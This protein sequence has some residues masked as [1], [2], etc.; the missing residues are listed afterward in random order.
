M[1]KTEVTHPIPCYKYP[2]TALL[3]DDDISFL[4]N[5]SAQLIPSLRFEK[6][7]KPKML[8]DILNQRDTKHIITDNVIQKNRDSHDLFGQFTLDYN[9]IELYQYRHSPKKHHEISL[10]IVD[11]AMPSM[12]G[13]EFCQHIND[14]SIKKIM[15]TGKAD[16]QVAVDAFNQGIIDKFILK[17]EANVIQA[18]NDAI[19]ACEHNYF[20]EKSQALLNSIAHTNSYY[21]ADPVIQALI[22]SHISTLNIHEYYMLDT[23][24][25]YL[26]INSKGE[27]SILL[28]KSETDLQSYYDIANDNDAPDTLL[29]QLASK[30][31]MPLLLTESDYQLPVSNW[32]NLLHPTNCLQGEKKYYY[33]HIMKAP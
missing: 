29:K 1:N 25:S 33:S 32:L 15:L 20:Y 18:L 31:A 10:A 22:Q 5:L 2:T 16:Y 30:Q 26:F 7:D 12:T 23:N 13:I 14:P 21:V 24:G 28:I 9:I 19:L 4:N 6:H 27:L 17:S 3:V 11:Y 8:L